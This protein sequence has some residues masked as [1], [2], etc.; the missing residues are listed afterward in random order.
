MLAF[1]HIKTNS[2]HKAAL[3]AE[4]LDFFQSAIANKSDLINFCLQVLAIF[5]QLEPQMNEQYRIIYRALLDPD[6]WKDDNQSVMSSYIQFIIAY[7]SRERSSLISDRPAIEV[8]LSKVIEIDHIELF[9]RFLEA[10]MLNTTLQEFNQSGYMGIF[11]SGSQAIGHSIQ[12]KKATLLFT[13]K[14]IL[15]YSNTQ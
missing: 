8:I 5:L 9:F 12:G 11:I 14:L 3:E 1:Y 4:V 7:L 15:Q 2:R 10:I 6:N 13:S